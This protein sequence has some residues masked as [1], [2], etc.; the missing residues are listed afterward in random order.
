MQ[1]KTKWIIGGALAGALLIGGIGGVAAEQ[2]GTGDDDRPLTGEQ[3]DRATKAALEETKGGK[4]TDTETGDDGAAYGVEVL[5]DDGRQVEVNL[6]QNY[7]VTNT[8][9]DDDSNEADDDRDDTEPD[10]D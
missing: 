9:A 10:D 8:E 5:G 7:K 6:D 3:Y 2:A 1:R 4:V